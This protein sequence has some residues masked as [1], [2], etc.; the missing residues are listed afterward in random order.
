[1]ADRSLFPAPLTRELLFTV[2]PAFAV[3]NTG[4]N[5]G[6]V[7]L[8][9]RSLHWSPDGKVLAFSESQADKTHTWIALLSLVDSTHTTA[10]VTVQVRTSILV[11]LSRRWLD[12]GF[13]SE[14]LL[15]VLWRTSMLCPLGWRT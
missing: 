8:F 15:R 1:M 4:C 11:L 10:Y 5:S 6:P 2:I 9:P 3:L 13:R 7:S 12:R 14:G